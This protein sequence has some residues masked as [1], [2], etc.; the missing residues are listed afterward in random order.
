MGP[1]F[2]LLTIVRKRSILGDN[3]KLQPVFRCRLGFGRSA[4]VPYKIL[5]NFEGKVVEAFHFLVKAGGEFPD[6]SSSDEYADDED[7][8]VR[9]ANIARDIIRDNSLSPNRSPAANAAHMHMARLQAASAMDHGSH[10][11]P[12]PGITRG[13]IISN[14]SDGSKMG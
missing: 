2:P 12:A 8:F 13:R 11:Y 1:A 4:Y 9:A 5:N 10:A 6:D 7:D 14:A 3:G